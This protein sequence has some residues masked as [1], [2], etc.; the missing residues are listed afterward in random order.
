MRRAR[1]SRSRSLML[2]V[3][4]CAACVSCQQTPDTRT[5]A[6]W[7]SFRGPAT[8]SASLWYPPDGDT[9]STIDM[10]KIHNDDL[11]KVFTYIDSHVDDHVANLQKWIQQP[12]VSNSGKA[13]PSRPRW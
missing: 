1:H 13:F 11:K 2:S 6:S 3:A 8:A 10:S 9:T 5:A 4:I 12:S 7:R